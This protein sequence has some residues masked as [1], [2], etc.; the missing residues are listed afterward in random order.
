[1]S[2]GCTIYT[3]SVIEGYR[4][5]NSR[6][7]MELLLSSIEESEAGMWKEQFVD[8]DQWVEHCKSTG[9]TKNVFS[10]V[11]GELPVPD[12]DVFPFENEMA[13]WMASYVFVSS[14]P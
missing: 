2:G 4:N 14:K 11:Y 8:V 10:K 6:K 12:T 1:M 3:K 5:E 13:Q 9:F 7:W